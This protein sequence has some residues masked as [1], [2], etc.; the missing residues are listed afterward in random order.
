MS[1]LL[2]NVA[3]VIFSLLCV[4]K[5]QAL[6]CLLHDVSRVTNA[7]L[8]GALESS[9]S[10]AMLFVY[11]VSGYHTPVSTAGTAVHHFAFRAHSLFFLR[12][13]SPVAL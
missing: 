8:F 2:Q 5:S 6:L 13:E 10:L 3:A 7:L 9:L 12:Q 4:S 1:L 11:P